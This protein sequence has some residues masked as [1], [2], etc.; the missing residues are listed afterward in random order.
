MVAVGRTRRGFVL[1]HLLSVRASWL[2]L[3]QLES[4]HGNE[5]LGSFFDDVLISAMT[6]VISAVA[7]LECYI[8]EI[9][10][11]RAQNFPSVP[12]GTMD[13]LWE[14]YSRS[15]GIIEKY[16]AACRLITN[17]ALDLGRRP[18]QDVIALIM[19]RNALVHFQPEW[20]DE[21]VL[22]EKVSGALRH[23]I[24]PNPWFTNDAG[25]SP[26]AW[27]SADCVWWALK[28]TVQFIEELEVATGLPPKLKDIRAR[29]L[30]AP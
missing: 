30:Q 16:S 11:D 8:N 5:P 9:F 25:L 27:A 28:N 4:E 26:T 20:N 15:Y 6:G 19:L 29:L 17:T 18:A 14:V 22:H 7:A 23:K 3:R 10:A 1:H 12:K 13:E 2:N 24:Q 21:R